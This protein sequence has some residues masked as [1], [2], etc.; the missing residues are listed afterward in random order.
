MKIIPNGTTSSFKN[1][2]WPITPRC[3]DVWFVRPYG[4]ALWENMQQALDKR[5]KETGHVNAAFPL[6]IP[7]SFLEKEKE[8]VEGFS[9]E[10]AVVTIGGGEKLEEPLVVRPDLRDGHRLHVQQMDQELPR[11]AGAHQPVGQRRPL[12]TADPPVPAY[13]RILLAGGATPPTP[14]KPKAEAETRRMLDVYT[15]FAINEAAVPVLAGYEKCH[16]KVRRPLARSYTI[17][18]MMGDTKAL[19]SGTSHNLGQNFAQGHSRSNI[20][21]KTMNCNTAGPPR[22]AFRPAL[23]ARSS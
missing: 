2:R 20:S 12:G 10:L 13:P 21:T 8:H 16:R 3:A 9:P 14:P 11:S 6:F 19:Q 15:D 17:E 1:L 22:G 18:A 7:M 5:F 23:S 4:W